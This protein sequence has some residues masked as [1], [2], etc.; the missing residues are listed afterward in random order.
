MEYKVFAGLQVSTWGTYLPHQHIICI[1]ELETSPI[2]NARQSG[3]TLLQNMV[4]E[5]LTSLV[6]PRETLCCR[7][8]ATY[9]WHWLSS[10]HSWRQCCSAE[11]MKKNYSDSSACKDYCADTNVL[12]C[13][14]SYAANKKT[15]AIRCSAIWNNHYAV[16]LNW[17]KCSSGL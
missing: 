11:L 15:K 16:Q 13:F 8:C 3:S 10:V 6:R 12:T 14:L 4:K 7:L 1:C 5:A 17:I 2:H 9:H